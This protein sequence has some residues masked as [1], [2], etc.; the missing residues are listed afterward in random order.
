MQNPSPDLKPLL[1]RLVARSNEFEIALLVTY[2]HSSGDSELDEDAWKDLAIEHG[3]EWVDGKESDVVEDEEDGEKG[4]ARVVGAL[5]AHMWEGMV[6]ETLEGRGEKKVQPVGVNK[7]V[8]GDHRGLGAPPL[9]EPRP[10]IPTPLAFPT[11][12][13]PSIARSSTASGSNFSTLPPATIPT[14]PPTSSDLA[15]LATFDDDF[16]PFVPTLPTTS[17]PPLL[18]PSPPPPEPSTLTALY[19]HPE[20]AFP[21]TEDL[22][23]G[24]QLEEG[25][26]E[27]LLELVERLRGLR[28]TAK[29]LGVEERREMAER[30]VAGLLGE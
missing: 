2:P 16:A 23:L 11:T 17:F 3:F 14:P 18:P 19:R 29:G 22:L 27:D 9:P 8:E 21:D 24:G 4:I 10:F 12:F 1:A 25:E 30:V 26:E 20:L 28:E 6:R 7:E 5:H 13:L 15:P